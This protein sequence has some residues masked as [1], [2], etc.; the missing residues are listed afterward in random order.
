VASLSNDVRVFYVTARGVSARSFLVRH[1][2]TFVE[3]G[4][5]PYLVCS[6]DAEAGDVVSRTG[7]KHLSINLRVD[8]S[9]LYDVKALIQLIKHIV[10][11]KPTAV[12]GHMS[13]GGFASMIASG[14]CRV[15]IRVYHNHGMACFSAT[16]MR[17]HLLKVIEKTACWCATDVLFCSESTMNQAIKM[18]LC[19]K[20][21]ARVL[22][23]GTI[24]G[25]DTNRFS[26]QSAKIQSQAL[27]SELGLPKLGAGHRIVGFVGRIVPH[28]GIDTLIQAWELLKP[29]TRERTT[30]VLAGANAGDTLFGRLEQL[31]ESNDSVI[32]LGRIDNIVGLYGLMDILVLPSWHE[33]FPYSVL[34]AQACGTPAVLTRVTGNVDAVVNNHTGIFVDL[35]NAEQLALAIE[36]LLDSEDLLNTLG[37]NAARRVVDHYQ[38][39]NVLANLVKFYDERLALLSL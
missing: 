36:N 10:R 26:Q 21:K 19:P 32:Y 37:D 24:S 16:G 9:P 8:I 6:D 29:S 27:V 4:Y 5:K 23:G 17:K 2:E 1:L 15:P 20:G 33:G 18:G 31:I 3:C 30:L 34:E 13:K 35:N 11:E 25:V 7:I 38:E 39:A 12:H 22:G 28:K 14:L